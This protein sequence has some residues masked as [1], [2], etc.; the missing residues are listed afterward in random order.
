LPRTSENNGVFP[1]QRETILSRGRPFGLPRFGPE[2]DESGL[3]SLDGTLM[4]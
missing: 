2:H 1:G 3:G 4:T